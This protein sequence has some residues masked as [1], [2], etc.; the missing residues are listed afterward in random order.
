MTFASQCQKHH[1]KAVVGHAGEDVTDIYMTV[2]DDDKV[3]VVD[4]VEVALPVE[5]V[6]LIRRLFG[7]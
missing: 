5:L 7:A 3:K 2:S 1:V 6:A 4:A